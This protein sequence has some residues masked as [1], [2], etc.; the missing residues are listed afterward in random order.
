MRC[1]CGQTGYPVVDPCAG[2]LALRVIVDN[3]DAGVEFTK[4]PNKVIKES[5]D[6]TV[7]VVDRRRSD[8]GQ[9]AQN[10]DCTMVT[11]LCRGVEGGLDKIFQ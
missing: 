2:L 6:I 4:R 3:S 8:E 1:R 9:A 7:R 11:T 10:W 5:P